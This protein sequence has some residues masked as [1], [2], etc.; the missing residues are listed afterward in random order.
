MTLGIDQVKQRYPWNGLVDIDYTIAWGDG[1]AP[2]LDDNLEVLMVDKSV[3][4]AVTNR[5]VT[6]LQ[7]RLPMTTGTHRVT[8]DAHAD[9]KT[10]YTDNAEF[11]AKIV[12]Y[13]ASYMVIDVSEGSREDAV[14]RV[15]FLNGEPQDG[16]NVDEYKGN[17]IAFRRIHPGSFTAGSPDGE[18]SRDGT[19]EEQHDVM[20]SRPYYIGIFEITQTQYQKVMNAN[21][22]KY[23]GEYRPAES[24]SY[25]GLR[26]VSSSKD[27]PTETSFI[28]K[29]LKRCKSKNAATGVYDVEVKGIDLPTE[30]Q[31]EYACRAGTTAPFNGAD[32]TGTSAE[33][34]ARV[35]RYS[36][37]CGDK[38]GGDYEQH[39]KVGSYEPNAWGLYDMHGNVWEWCRDQY[40]ANVAGLNQHVDPKGPDSGVL[41]VNRGGSWNKAEGLCRSAARNDSATSGAFENGGFR[42]S[43]T[44]P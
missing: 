1:E 41:S 22:S 6:F 32:S 36:G 7:V 16:F 29:M 34:M 38:K 15:D 44:L 23:R 31:W 11:V 43:L 25:S 5:V 24:V 9:G 21:Y 13:A 14:Y 37:N 42:L 10:N 8:W 30:F 12:H 20:L 39:T 28:G 33:Q 27:E 17:K 26:G 4:P 40:V 35:G 19:R 18:E 3:N 2:G